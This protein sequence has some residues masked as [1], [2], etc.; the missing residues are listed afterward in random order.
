MRC[1]ILTANSKSCMFSVRRVSVLTYRLRPCSSSCASRSWKTWQPTTAVYIAASSLLYRRAVIHTQMIPTTRVWSRY[2][3]P[4][5]SK[6]SLTNSVPQREGKYRLQGTLRFF[7]FVANKFWC[8]I[9]V[10]Y[11]LHNEWGHLGWRLEIGDYKVAFIHRHGLLFFIYVGTRSLS[12]SC[13]Y[14]WGCFGLSSWLFP[15]AIYRL[16]EVSVTVNFHKR[17]TIP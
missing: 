12:L 15:S 9:E 5:V 3:E 14:F 7:Y 16:L 13:A 11:F 17:P 4:R 2:Q 8:W 1:H 10:K 6:S